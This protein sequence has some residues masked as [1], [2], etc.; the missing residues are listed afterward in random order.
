MS[1][2][3]ETIRFQII[4]NQDGAT[5]L[6]LI[7]PGDEPVSDEQLELEKAAHGGIIDIG[8]LE[9]DEK[10]TVMMLQAIDYKTHGEIRDLIRKMVEAVW[11]R[12]KVNIKE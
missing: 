5:D 10:N 4:D 7:W 6:E 2:E 11:A 12:A 3:S 8:E 1:E 9:E